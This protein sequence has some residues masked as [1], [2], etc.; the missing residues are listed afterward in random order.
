[1]SERRS[2]IGRLEGL[3]EHIPGQ[4]RPKPVR[5]GVIFLLILALLVYIA[6]SGSLPFVPA[7]GREYKAEFDR[8]EYLRGGA[9][10]RIAGVTVGEVTAVER[11]ADGSGALVTFR[12]TDDDVTLYEDARTALYWR[13]L[14]GFSYEFELRP[15]SEGSP[16]LPEGATIPEQRSLTQVMVD[17]ALQPL[18]QSGRGAIRTFIEEVG[19]GFGGEAPGETI[20]AA[21][22]AAKELA[23]ALDAL[24]GEAN[25]DLARL[26]DRTGEAMAAIGREEVALSGLLED[27]AATLSAVERQRAALG[28]TVATGPETMDSTQQT[29]VRLRTT[30]DELDPLA[31]R[32]RPGAR[33]LSDATRAADAA[34]EEAAPLLADAEPLLADLDAAVG[35]LGGAS[36]PGAAVARELQEPV[37]RANDSLLPA[38]STTYE[39]SG[40]KTY[41][42]IGPFFSATGG[43][44]AQ[45]N[46]EGGHQVHF[47]PGAGANALESYTPCASNLNSSDPQAIL[48]C[49]A[50]D[51]YFESIMNPSGSSAA[52]SD[53]AEDS[54][55]EA[56][57]TDGSGSE[58][59]RGLQRGVGKLADGIRAAAQ[60][61]AEGDF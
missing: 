35:A 33:R 28:A 59:I 27:S 34:V 42:A 56:A 58:A 55:S 54:A 30:L 49:K 22:P 39:D 11:Q 60:K 31:E 37:R 32:L 13:T 9:P 25:G 48:A 6:Y 61:Q 16:E 19:T 7:G 20:E 24:G 52:S 15:G 47:G 29:M 10:V 57:S 4:Y 44:T 3:F 5:D 43:L 36:G 26:V 53:Q 41:A 21:G 50:F 46:K 40:L 2:P 17:E 14:L 45:F 12:V 18:D 51:D 8:A 38:L 1:M 23:P